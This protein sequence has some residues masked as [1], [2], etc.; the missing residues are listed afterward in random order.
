MERQ[1][2][3]VLDYLLS[4]EQGEIMK[5]NGQKLLKKN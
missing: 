2:Q 5:R 3:I 1:E 4:S